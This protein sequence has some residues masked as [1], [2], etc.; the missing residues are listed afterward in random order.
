[1]LRIENLH[2]SF[3]EKEVL[4]GISIDVPDGKIVGF[5]GKNDAGKMTTLRCAAGILE[6][7]KGKIT[8]D[9]IDI[10]KDPLGAKRVLAYLPDNPDL[11]DGLSGIQYLSFVAD[12]YGVDEKVRTN[13]ITQY[14][15][16]LE[17][18]DRL[19]D[20]IRTLSHGTKQKVA[21][22]SALLHA[23][24]LFYVFMVIGWISLA[25]VPAIV[26]SLVGWLIRK[27]TAGRK[28]EN[29]WRIVLA[30]A[31]MFMVMWM[32]MVL[33]SDRGGSIVLDAGM[34]VSKILPLMSLYMGALYRELPVCAAGERHGDCRLPFGVEAA[35]QY[36]AARHRKRRS[37]IP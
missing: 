24:A 37:G 23:P 17:I 16:E 27:L 26:T 12:I 36:D 15:K 4:H 5:I 22:I 31:F 29:L 25:L 11:Y 18:Y 14:A 21:V 34:R 10:T 32:S 3:G 1:M 13:R 9:G 19:G 28:H 8:I 6:F 33:S 20:P 2:K 30:L 7:D 35:G